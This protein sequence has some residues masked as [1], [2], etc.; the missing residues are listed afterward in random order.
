[1][2]SLSL[3]LSLQDYTELK[4][5]EKELEKIKY[6]KV[7]PVYKAVFRHTHTTILSHH[8]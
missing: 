4:K 6:S 7:L 2:P 8:N 3:S 1:M 5:F